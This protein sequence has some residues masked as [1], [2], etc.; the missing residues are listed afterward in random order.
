MEN[1]DKWVK[2]ILDSHTLSNAGKRLMDFSQELKNDSW[3]H[4]DMKYFYEQVRQRILDYDYFFNRNFY[5][6]SPESMVAAV[7]YHQMNWNTAIDEAFGSFW[8]LGEE[9]ATDYRPAAGVPPSQKEVKEALEHIDRY[10]DILN[11]LNPTRKTFVIVNEKECRENLIGS[12]SK[13]A[14]NNGEVGYCLELF[15]NDLNSM[16]SVGDTLAILLM[17]AL[18]TEAFECREERLEYCRREYRQALHYEG[19]LAGI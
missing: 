7:L 16:M 14:F 8:R 12:S 19:L 17:N 9:L 13:F 4:A 3:C 18:C 5:I 10:F 2:S 15:P 1:L 6:T 11:L